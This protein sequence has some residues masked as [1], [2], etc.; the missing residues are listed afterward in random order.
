MITLRSL[1]RAGLHWAQQVVTE[2]HYL[3]TPVDARCSV[4]GYAVDVD[5]LG[6]GR[7]GVLL[8][9]RPEATRCGNWYGGVEDARAGR[10]EVTRWQVLNLARVWFDP[11]TQR[12]G[13]WFSA[14]YLPGF[15]DRRGVWRSTL[16]TTA[17][18]QAV[19]QIGLD[20]LLRR[21]PCFLDEPYEIRW[22]LSYCDTRLHRGV[23]YQQSGFELY[24]TNARSIQTWRI[25]LPALSEEQD[26]AIQA[27]SLLNTRSQRYRAQ[28]AQMYLFNEVSHA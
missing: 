13:E 27:A 23:I 2:Q 28:R 15:V 10:C 4:E 12:G 16:A 18:R 6:L 11:R 17:I 3:H 24:R 21:P 9:G 26:A 20:Y 14:A 22:L 7:I 25:R 19:Q 8:F 5:G 1:D